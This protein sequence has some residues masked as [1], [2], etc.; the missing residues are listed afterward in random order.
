LLLKQPHRAD[1]ALNSQRRLDVVSRANAYFA[2]HYPEPIE[3]VALA[4]HLGVSEPC[5]SFCFHQCRGKTPLQALQVYR[6]SQLYRAITD[7]PADPLPGQVA[8]CGLPGLSQANALFE[9]FFGIN[10]AS[11]RHTSHRA[12]VDRRLRAR[13]PEPEYLLTEPAP[14]AGSD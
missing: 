3:M 1:L 9:D 7:H 8:A 10:L 4:S 11:F 5:L 2:R 13:H 14:A 12:Q 6:L